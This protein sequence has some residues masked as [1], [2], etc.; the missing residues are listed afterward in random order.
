MSRCPHLGPDGVEV[1]S[2]SLDQH[3]GFR[4]VGLSRALPGER[5]VVD[6]KADERVILAGLAG[7]DADVLEAAMLH[8]PY[9][10]QV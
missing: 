3:L 9:V 10:C 4:Q 7:R 6:A 2:P 8:F 1:T 5:Q